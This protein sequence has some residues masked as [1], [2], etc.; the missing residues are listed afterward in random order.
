MNLYALLDIAG[1]A[2][3]YDVSYIMG[4]TTRYWD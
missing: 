4:A 1:K 3:A 2:L